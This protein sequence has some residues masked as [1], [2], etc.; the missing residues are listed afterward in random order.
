MSY[1]E[2]SEFLPI[3]HYAVDVDTAADNVAWIP[4]QTTMVYNM[5]GNCTE[6]CAT[7]LANTKQIAVMNS[8]GTEMY[9]MTAVNS[10]AVGSEIEFA[11]ETG[12]SFPMK[13]VKGTTYYI[14]AG[15]GVETSKAGAFIVKMLGTPAGD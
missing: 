12:Y 11:A 9:T 15:A 3:G 4:K 5:T 10:T 2:K 7:D 1:S 13:F 6:A 8:S 14:A